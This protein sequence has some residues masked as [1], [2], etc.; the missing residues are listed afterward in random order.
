MDNEEKQQTSSSD[1]VALNDDEQSAVTGGVGPIGGASLVSEKEKTYID[2]HGFL[3]LKKTRITEKTS[4]W[5][6][7][8]VFKDITEKPLK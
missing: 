5:S 2:H 3:W 4:T 6:D 7:G 1:I 8:A